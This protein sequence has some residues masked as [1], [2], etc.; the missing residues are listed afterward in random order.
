[1][2]LIIDDAGPA[3][4]DT[5]RFSVGGPADEEVAPLLTF[6]D[7]L[8][9][10]VIILV[11]FSSI[12]VL[13]LLALLVLQ[14][15]SLVRHVR[16]EAKPLID[17]TQKTVQTV[18]GTSSFIGSELVRPLIATVSVVRGVQR[19]LQVM[20]DLRTWNVK[21]ENYRQLR[22]ATRKAE[23]LEASAHDAGRGA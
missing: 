4:Q 8:K 22:A 18:R 12:A 16:A 17:E 15:M 23:E 3:G 7:V 14:V 6:L 19:G 1:L 2:S 13:I 20:G 21:T 9:D 10:V 11:A 5:G